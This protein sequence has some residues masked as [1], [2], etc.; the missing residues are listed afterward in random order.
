MLFLV[1]PIKSGYWLVMWRLVVEYGRIK[2]FYEFLCIHQ[3]Y[4]TPAVIYAQIPPIWNIGI[5]V[6]SM[7]ATT[8]TVIIA[9]PGKSNQ[10]IDPWLTARW[11]ET[12]REEH[13]ILIQM[14]Q[15]WVAVSALL[16][17]RVGS[18][19]GGARMRTMR[20][21]VWPAAAPP[22]PI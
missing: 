18:L 1:Q 14:I 19:A 7:M 13:I 6:I 15:D 17:E 16:K 12:A 9:P 4:A 20:G 5:D 8:C 22:D 21:G 11:A 3:I 2:S 10:S